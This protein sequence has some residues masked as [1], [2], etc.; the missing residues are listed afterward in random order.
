M[1]ITRPMKLVGGAVGVSVAFGSVAVAAESSGGDV[2]LRDTVSI[3]QAGTVRPLAHYTATTVD[4]DDSFS[5]PFDADGDGLSDIEEAE[6]GTDPLNPDSDADGLTDYQEVKF[7]SDPLN[8]DT[9][10]DGLPD[11]FELEELRTNPLESDTDHD[12]LSD[13]D[14]Y[15]IHGTDPR[16]PDTDDDRLNDG[17]E[18]NT[19]KT[20]PLHWDTD[21]DGYGDGDEIAFGGDPL[22]PGV[23]PD[24]PF[25]DDS[26]DTSVSLDSSV[27]FDSPDSVDSD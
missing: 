2:S 5:S 11:G 14:E 12:G 10:G 26:L 17:D 15:T 22:D 1:D 16:D 23:V 19:Y 18:F 25:T 7:G 21:R 20:D 6:L 13:G 9:D 24:I 8:P 3:A 4:V 27:S